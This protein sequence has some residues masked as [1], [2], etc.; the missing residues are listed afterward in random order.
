VEP[1]Q[2]VDPLVISANKFETPREQIAASVSVVTEED[3]RTYHYPSVDEAL[4]NVPGLDIRR[5]GGFGKTSAV[6][7]RG[8]N[9]NQVQILVDGVRVKSPTLGQMDLSDLSPDLIDR[10][11]VIRGPQSTLY[12]ADA[13][14]GV[15]HI[16]TKRGKGPFSATVQQEV[17]NRDTLRS[18]GSVQ[19][20]W[21]LFDYAASAS[22]LESNGQWKNDGTSTNAA[23]LQLGL[24][25]PWET[26]IGFTLRWNRNDTDLPV[27]FICCGPLPVQPFIDTN[28]QQQSETTVM[29]LDARTRPFPWWESRARISRYQNSIGFQDAMDQGYDFDFPSFALIS[30]ERREAEWVNAFHVG[31]WSTSTLGLEHR[32]EEGTNRSNTGVFAG[33]T[34]THALF[35]EQQFRLWDRLFLSGGFRIE[36]HSV[37]GTETTER[38]GLAFVIK[39][40]GTRLHGSAGSGFRAP[41]LNDLFFPGF[42]NPELLP[43]HSFSWDVGVDQKL[44]GDRVRLGL[45]FFSNDFTNL[46]RFVPI[47]SFPFVAVINVAHARAAGIEFTA[48][49]DILPN[50]VAFV[51]YTYTDSE[52]LPLDRPLV[53]EPRHRWH[54]GVTWEP[55]ARLSLWLQ[56]HASTRQFESGVVGYNRG[57]TRVDVGGTWR[58]IARAGWLE[59]LDLIARIQNVLNEDYAEVRGFPALG[60]QA[61]VGVRARF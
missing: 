38:G 46:I 32:R 59:S 19:G 25:L 26:R 7:I 3:F 24:S 17:G 39:E 23:N 28:A 30:V 10:I 36:D 54:A 33:R 4:R 1:S 9:A 57:H 56:V 6:S 20:S 16:I 40:T 18:V 52:D 51:N 35:F 13:I 55:I 15:V 27:K 60:I 41:T 22:H 29:S 8:A 2:R 49:A 11:E 44:F 43:E 58:A 48:E 61:L 50:L 12:G 21:K 34:E 45:T 37:F 47:S 42:S 14:G 53:R 31:H 5:S